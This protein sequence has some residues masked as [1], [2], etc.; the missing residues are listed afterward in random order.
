[1]QGVFGILSMTNNTKNLLSGTL[2]VPP[3]E[4]GEGIVVS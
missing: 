2:S 3:A 1:L 4:L